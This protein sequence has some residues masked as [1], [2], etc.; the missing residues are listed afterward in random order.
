MGE[1]RITYQLIVLHSPLAPEFGKPLLFALKRPALHLFI[2]H[3]LQRAVTHAHQREHRAAVE[4]VPTLVAE[5]RAEPA[6]G[7]QIDGG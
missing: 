5:Y 4:P 2:C 3:K 7:I 6:W 1:Q